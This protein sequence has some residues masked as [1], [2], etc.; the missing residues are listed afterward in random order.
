MIACSKRSF[1]LC[2]S[3]AEGTRTL[4]P[5]GAFLFLILSFTSQT[6]FA[7]QLEDAATIPHVS[8]KAKD[9]F[10]QYIYAAKNKAYA[11]APGGAW[12]WSDVAATEEEAKEKALQQCQSYTQQTCVLYAAN[13]KI[14]FNE[15]EWP[16]LWRLENY[17]AKK[18]ASKTPSRGSKFPN[19]KFKDRKGKT[20]NLNNFK[21]KITLVHFWGSWCPPC[22]REMPGLLQLQKELKKNFGSKVELVLLQVREPFKE[23]IKWAKQQ[24]FDK[25]PLYDS[26]VKDDSDLYLRTVNEKKISDRNL[27]K[28]F[29][30][31]YVLDSQRKV[32]FSHRGPIDDWLEYLPFFED[33]VK[34]NKK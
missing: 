29:P 25:L 19:L 1:Y 26:G 24:D 10:I 31:S 27:A 22:M 3:G 6:S 33:A 28:V 14:L 32:L 11:I 34:N 2:N 30:S 5:F 8:Q 17:Q 21:N 15:A 20:Y 23:S 7:L 4:S 13:D 18:S 12:A 9:S 16:R